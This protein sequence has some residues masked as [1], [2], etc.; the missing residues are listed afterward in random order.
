MPKKPTS[1]RLDDDT[2]AYLSLRGA[3]VSGGQSAVIN[4]ALRLH[5]LISDA[6][7][8]TKNFPDLRSKRS[9][10]LDSARLYRFK[11]PFSDEA[12]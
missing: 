4:D 10:L 12:C 7:A 9:A 1:H 11:H 2:R 3:T 5:A 8:F 6:S